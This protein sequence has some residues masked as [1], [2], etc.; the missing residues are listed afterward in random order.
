MKLLATFTVFAAS[1]PNLTY[2]TAQIPDQ[3]I[4]DGKPHAL[5]TEPL[6]RYLVESGRHSKLKPYLTG[7]C[8]G[9]WR[10]FAAEWRVQTDQLELVKVLANPCD[11]EPKEV[12]LLE[13]FPEQASPIVASWFSGR[14]VV[15]LGEQT[16]Y[17]H[18][19]YESKYERYLVLYVERGVI[20]RREESTERPK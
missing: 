3:I 14:L 7:M 6:T 2:A 18:M 11:K 10:G 20:V 9:S 13:L 17:V 1:L 12:P 5:F 15:P 16:Q 19:G 4:V 8:S